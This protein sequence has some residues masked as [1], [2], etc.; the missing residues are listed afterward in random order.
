MRTSLKTITFL[1]IIGMLLVSCG[2]PG[3]KA[4]TNIDY[5]KTA[6]KVRTLT[7]EFS[8]DPSDVEARRFLAKLNKVLAP[9]SKQSESDDLTITPVAVKKVVAE[10]IAQKVQYLGDITGD[11]S[12]VVYPKLTDTVWDIYVENGDYVKKGELLAKIDD[13]TVRASKAQAQ[14]AYLSAK[15]QVANVNVEFE[16]MKTLYEAKA[17][18][19]SQWD[20]LVTQKEVAEAGLEQAKAALSMAETQLTYA[21]VTAPISGYVSNLAYRIGDMSTPQK[22]FLTIH[23]TE[24]VKINI[25]VTESDLGFI[26]V[27]Q[28]T[29]IHLS[30][31][32]NQIFEG[33]V[34]TVSPV[35]DP[36][37]RT[38]KIEIIAK[39]DDARLK[40][41]MFARV[42]IVTQE[43]DQAFT[44]EKAVTNKQTVLERS[45][46][47][48]REDK[49]VET[50]SCFIVRDGIAINRELK[51]GIQSK[52]KYE[53]LS[54]LTEGDLV[55]VMGQNNL[56]D[57]SLVNIVE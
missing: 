42:D 6:D 45:E 37:T 26:K 39:N 52:T 23:Q 46:T 28:R 57:S 56:S 40:P 24:T 21:S 54:G 12:V 5:K 31:Y 27:G 2:A 17:I 8:A 34:E 30:S 1:M 25:N 35:I 16:R 32:P 15:S 9:A 43:R 10:H 44:I 33:K 13:A 22:P 20:Q 11:P 36:M 49:V 29:E 3:E 55:V 14:G 50:Y 53:V 19:D 48:L 7:N 38:A 47:N 4:K 18:S 51:I 41:G